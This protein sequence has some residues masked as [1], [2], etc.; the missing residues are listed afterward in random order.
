MYQTKALMS[1]REA[2][3]SARTWPVEAVEIHDRI[4][5]FREFA[6]FWTNFERK[7]AEGVTGRLLW[8]RKNT[9]LN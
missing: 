5:R 6:T 7:I 3:I 9:P 2:G 4:S 8:T 1:T